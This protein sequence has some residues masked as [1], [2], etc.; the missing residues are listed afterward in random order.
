MKH[1]LLLAAAM[2]G[3]MAALAVPTPLAAQVRHDT[4][5]SVFRDWRTLQLGEVKNGATDYSAPALARQA[6]GLKQLRARLDA[7]PTTG[8]TVSQKVDREIIR[9]EM[10]GLDFDL[11]VAK[12]WERD[13]AWYLSV[14]AA[15]SDTPAHEGPVH[16][17]P[18]E[19]WTYSF[20]LDAAASKKLAGELAHIPELLRQARVNLTGNARDLWT[21]SLVTLGGQQEALDDLQRKVAGGDPKLVRAVS[22]AATATRSFIAWVKA[23]AP[24]KTGPSG[25]GIENYNWFL[26]NVQL[27]TLTWADEVAIMQRELDRS[28]AALRMEEQRNRNLPQLVG[29]STP[30]EYDALAAASVRKYMQF[31]KDKDILTIRDYMEPELMKRV[32]SYVP[33]E[34]QNFFHIV[35]HRAPMTLWTHYY[36]W[37]DLRMMQADPHPSEVRRGPLLYNVW[38]SRSEGMATAVEEL[39]LHAG[40]FDDEPRSREFVWIMQAQRAARGLASLYAQANMIDLKAAM[41][42][43]VA[44]TPNGYMS[45]TLPLL[46]FEQ[47]MYL[48]LP[49][50]G[51]SYITGKAMIERLLT[52]MAEDRGQRFRPRE[53]FDGLNRHGM[54]PLSLIRWEM[55]GKTDELE[56]LGIKP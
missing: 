40:L 46:G 10:N 4:L 5:E 30:Q 26:K 7:L 27:S 15:Q 45:P 41:D 29:A 23:E 44:R 48:R 55:L 25:V 24:R 2:M 31:L 52:E 21:A 22:D 47:Q 32:G 34:K 33:P 50:Y 1:G 12:P 39:M 35:M 14:W 37:W 42:M 36:H 51:P 56:K 53:F 3:T 9:A 43:Q 13:P 38:L 16:P 11:R 54:I 18:V 17:M 6:A 8:W 19:L 20:P 49:G 28:H